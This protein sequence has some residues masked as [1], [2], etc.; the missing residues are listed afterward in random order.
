MHFWL[1]PF[2][3]DVPL[4]GR[5]KKWDL[6][7]RIS[8][9][10]PSPFFLLSISFSSKIDETRSRRQDLNPH[11]PNLIHDALDHWTTMPCPNSKCLNSILFFKDAFQLYAGDV[12]TALGEKETA[13]IFTTFPTPGISQGI[14]FV[15]QVNKI[16]IGSKYQTTKIRN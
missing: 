1:A 4:P 5:R 2:H 3:G 11:P 7:L 9:R 10:S 14:G 12:R 6:K 16:Q 13:S 8:F 15:D